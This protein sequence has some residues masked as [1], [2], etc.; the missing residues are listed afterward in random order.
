MTKQPMNLT[1]K[2]E[3]DAEMEKALAEIVQVYRDSTKERMKSPASLPIYLDEINGDLLL[4]L[5]YGSAE[6]MRK[7]AIEISAMALR[8]AMQCG[9]K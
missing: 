2:P 4:D 5:V 3:E 6:T 1:G 9:G 7:K 8:F